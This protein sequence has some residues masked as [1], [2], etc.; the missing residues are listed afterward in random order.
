M[1][2][3]F[4]T[5]A[6]GQW[7]PQHVRCHGMAEQYELDDAGQSAARE[8]LA[9]LG[10]RGSPSHDSVG[11]RLADYAATDDTLELTIQPIQWSARLSAS[12]A[13]GT[14]ATFCIARDSEGRWL[15][16]KRADWVA[17]WPGRWTI[18]AGGGV[19]PGES[20]VD[21]LRRELE[22]EWSVTPQNLTITGLVRLRENMVWLVG[23]ATVEPTA[24]PEPDD[25]HTAWA[26]WPADVTAWP[27]EADEWAQA[28]AAFA[29]N[30]E[31]R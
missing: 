15:A 5:L 6:R 3:D 10:R 20:P 27:Q 4:D 23:S 11:T 17:L 16:A 14:L 21:A 8:A 9:E 31:A 26:W 19:E 25:E 22:E 12:D 24:T 18:G 13:H 7:R 29:A 28:M 2:A 1:A 30:V